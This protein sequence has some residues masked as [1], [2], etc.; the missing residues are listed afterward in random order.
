[1]GFSNGAFCKVWKIEHKSQTWARVNLS[2][3]VKDRDTGEYSTEFS[4][5]VD[6]F[7]TANVQ[8]LSRHKEGDRIQLERVDVR[9]PK[10]EETGKYY[11]NYIC[12]SFKDIEENS[13]G[14]SSTRKQKKPVDDGEV[15]VPDEP[16]DDYPF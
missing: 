16:D 2:V 15:E 9:T 7:G 13:G 4:G 10:D 5:F 8:H 12:W 1:M 11:T 3:S 14:G 6:F